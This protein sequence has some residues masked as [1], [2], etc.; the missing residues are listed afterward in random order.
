MR[1]RSRS[2][3]PGPVSNGNGGPKSRRASGS[4]NRQPSPRIRAMNET[5]DSDS[6]SLSSSDYE[7][8]QPLLSFQS[9]SEYVIPKSPLTGRLVTLTSTGLASRISSLNS[10]QSSSRSSSPSSRSSSP[11]R[12]PTAYKILGFPLVLEGQQGQYA[13]NEF[14]WNLCFVF[15]ASAEVE[16]FE[17][18]VRKCGRILRS[19]ELDSSYLSAPQPSHA[20][21]PAVLE[22]IFEDLNSYSETSIPLDGFN[23]LEL[24]LFPFYRE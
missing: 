23:S 21:M 3:K 17:P 24:K 20:P 14:R 2:S 11:E 10:G 8:D 6:E 19:A 13:R 15:E 22:Q 16:A 18:I 4:L 1:G 9:I 7:T 12:T 5:V